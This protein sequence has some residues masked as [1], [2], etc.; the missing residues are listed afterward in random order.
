M[1]LLL[2]PRRVVHE[3][4]C[5]LQP[6]LH[7]R[8]PVRY[9]LKRTDRLAELFPRLSVKY[10]RLELT[11]HRA[12]LARQEAASLPLHRVVEDGCRAP[13]ASEPVRHRYEALVEDHLR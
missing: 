5:S 1:A 3:Q 9:R 8:E 11:L 10:A 2:R 12:D 13:F 4:P 6:Y 7:V